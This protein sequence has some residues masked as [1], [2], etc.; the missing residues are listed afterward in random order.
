[1]ERVR[2]A[3]AHLGIA[4]QVCL[5]DAWDARPTPGDKAEVASKRNPAEAEPAGT[6]LGWLVCYAA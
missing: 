5:V 4:S 1:M 6:G 3:P 2:D